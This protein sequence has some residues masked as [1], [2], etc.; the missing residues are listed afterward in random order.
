MSVDIEDQVS[1][2]YEAYAGNINS[3]SGSPLPQLHFGS[4]LE[5]RIKSLGGEDI[6]I[7]SCGEPVTNP[8]GIT[9][10]R[11]DTQFMQGARMTTTTQQV[12]KITEIWNKHLEIAKALHELTADVSNAVDIIASSLASGGQLLVAGNGGSAADAQHITAELTG[13]F[14]RD[15]QPLRALALHANTSAL[16]AIGNDYG[17]EHVFAREL[18]AHARPGDV[19]LAIST[20]G[21]SVNILRAIEVARQAKVTVIGL[22]GASGGVM[23]PLCDLCLCI[24]SGSTARIQEMH[25][26]IGHAICELLEERLAQA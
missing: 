22:T 14:Q 17:Y 10:P 3:Y 21:N 20:S 7:R 5:S 25:I 16:T 15:R 24:P 13:R 19:F 12:D 9:G 4:R 6:P 2:G 23:R 11:M 26:T 18:S 1:G 8:A